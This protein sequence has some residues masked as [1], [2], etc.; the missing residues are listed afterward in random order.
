M[1]YMTLGIVKQFGLV[2][3]LA[4]CC[5][6]CGGGRHGGVRLSSHLSDLVFPCLRC[7]PRD[8][9]DASGRARPRRRRG[10]GARPSLTDEASRRGEVA[11]GCSPSPISTPRTCLS[12]PR[13]P[14]G[15]SGYCSDLKSFPSTIDAWRASL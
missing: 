7:S 11:L 10:W 5:S 15:C 13:G 1:N 3:T 14:R 12:P 2:G 9:S 4:P 8:I 6:G